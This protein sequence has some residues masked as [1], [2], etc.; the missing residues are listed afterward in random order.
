MK[1]FVTG[2]SGFVGSAVVPELIAGGHQVVGLARSDKSAAAVT[3][4]G[5][6]VL[7]GSLD[8]LDGL[9]QGAEQADAVIHCAFIHDFSN[10]AASAEA[11][12]RAIETMGEALAGSNRPFIVTSGSGGL[13]PGRLAT[14][15]I[16]GEAPAAVAAR[17]SEPLGLSFAARGV[18]V[19]IMRLPTSV[20]GK[21]D[22]GFVPYLINTARQKG[23]SAYIGEGAN[24]WPA[25]HRVDA[26]RLYRLALESAPAGTRLHPIGD[27]GVPT[28]EI[29]EVIGRHLNL[30]VVSIPADQAM[31]HFG[32]LGGIFQLDIPVSGKL[33]EERFDWHPTQPGLIAD[34]ESHYF[35]N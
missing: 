18:R 34:M 3:A 6:A 31:S 14:E 21:G 35:N 30:P 16:I 23:V 13:A 22:H 5:A 12:R 11:D 1:V 29:A 10:F 24:R 9:R 7:R 2:A 26:A 28:R 27:E 32:F 19:S 25:V 8:D 20:H 17:V 4:Q 33:T 15:D